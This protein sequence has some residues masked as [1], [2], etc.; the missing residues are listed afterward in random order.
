MRLTHGYLRQTASNWCHALRTDTYRTR[1][2]VPSSQKIP[3]AMSIQPSFKLV[4]YYLQACQSVAAYS[5][6][7]I[8][9]HSRN[10]SSSWNGT[11]GTSPFKMRLSGDNLALTTQTAEVLCQSIRLCIVLIIL[12]HKKIY[13]YIYSFIYAI[14]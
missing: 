10:V 7:Y 13:L 8:A 1:V 14:N 6:Y 9:Q 3:V 5:E 2:G 4:R 11:S 12:I